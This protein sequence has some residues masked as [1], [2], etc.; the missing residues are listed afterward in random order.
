MNHNFI[1]K[2]QS[3]PF[4]KDI[5]IKYSSCLHNVDKENKNYFLLSEFDY[6]LDLTEESITI[7]I[8]FC[9]NKKVDINSSNEN[10]NS[11][12]INNSNA[13][14]VNFLAK[15]YNVKLL[16]EKTEEYI[17]HH[18]KEIINQFLSLRIELIDK[19]NEDLLAQFISE[20]I[21]DDRLLFLRTSN[22]YR[23][24]SEFYL[25]QRKKGIKEKETNRKIIEFLFKYLE[26]NGIESS[27]LF[28]L[29]DI[30]DEDIDYVSFMLSKYGDN[31][32]F[33]FLSPIIFQ[34]INSR[35]RLQKI[36]DAKMQKEHEEKE[37]ELRKIANN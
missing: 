31:F 35:I 8:Q 23:I 18:Y 33:R 5:F 21:S 6:R 37:K 11:I 32:D 20:F 2:D 4:N 7:F 27:I 22:L 17:M 12:D 15:K 24:L 14:S 26:K 3:Y 25:Q 34:S 1:Y 30:N 19:L 28:S 16:I 13:L 9:Q 29:I 36:K 10:N